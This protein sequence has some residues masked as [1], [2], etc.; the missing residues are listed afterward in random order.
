MLN[1]K[2][3]T[4]ENMVDVIALI[5]QDGREEGIEQGEHQA[6]IATAKRMLAR[7]MDLQTIADITDLS[8]EEVAKIAQESKS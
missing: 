5:K 4:E 7:Q 3:R 6:K 2:L 1:N 8:L